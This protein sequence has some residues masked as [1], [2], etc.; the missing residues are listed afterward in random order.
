MNN[1]PI[2]DH[3]IDQ[4]IALKKQP[5]GF[6]QSSYT[7]FGLSANP[8]T[9]GH[10][11]FIQHLI[12]M[13]RMV[14]I[15]PNNQ[16]TLKQT[17]IPSTFKQQML[18]CMLD[19]YGILPG[20]YCLSNLEI[21]RPAPSRMITTLALLQQPVTL[22]LGLDTLQSFTR[23]SRWHDLSYFCDLVFYP[24]PLIYDTNQSVDDIIK[25]MS[26]SLVQLNQT[27]MAITFVY[28]TQTQRR[29]YEAIIEN[30]YSSNPTPLVRLKYEP[31]NLIESCS[32]TAVR[33]HYATSN[34]Y[35]PFVSLGVHQIIVNHG[36]FKYQS[37]QPK[38]PC[39]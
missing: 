35:H 26:S 13:G 23:W 18:Q 28:N 25:I 8:P 31:I 27:G 17:G 37:L 29:L 5:M 3:I 16:S 6:N 7:L 32:S 11:A 15:M 4:A 21:D 22:A 19:E 12:D 14:I 10:L 36:F 20:T 24:R 34:E 9:L 38:A 30:A 1:Q 2:E 33:N 39:P